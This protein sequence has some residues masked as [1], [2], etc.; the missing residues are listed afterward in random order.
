MNNLI[1]L[2][3]AIDDFT[4]NERNIKTDSPAC[5][6]KIFLNTKNLKTKNV[7]PII[8]SLGRGKSNYSFKFFKSKV[9]RLNGVVVIYAPFSKFKILSEFISFFWPLILIFRFNKMKEKVSVLYWNRTV[10][11]IPF[12]IASSIFKFR[13]I[14]DLED[15]NIPLT[16]LSFNYFKVKIKTKLYDTLCSHALVTCNALKTNLAIKNV[17]CHYG[18]HD[19]K[20]KK[21][22]VR[23]NDNI[24]FHFGGTVSEITGANLLLDAIKSL[25]KS[26]L[27]WL[28]KVTFIITGKGDSIADFKSLSNSNNPPFVNVYSD[29]SFHEYSKTLRNCHVGLALKPKSGNLSETT[30]PSKVIEIANNGLLLLSTD[31]SDVKSIF[32]EGA[33]YTNSNVND[34]VKLIEWIFFNFNKA[35]EISKIGSKKVE[36]LCCPEKL[37]S[38]LSN[39]LFS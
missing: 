21:M 13:N 3:N 9:T 12:L 19:N 24:N 11:Y 14:L 16:F 39:F 4:K 17:I 6:K 34:F 7:N 31:I 36:H 20:I 38:K 27:K 26:N 2:C 37:N 15:G 8:L 25:R 29:Q 23:K 35:K 1:Y 33:I 10:A 18:F 28:N 5:S 30:F 32:S 22:P